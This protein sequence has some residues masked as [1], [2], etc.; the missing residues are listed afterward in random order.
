MNITRGTVDKI[1]IKR[2]DTGDW[3]WM[4]HFLTNAFLVAVLHNAIKF[5]TCNSVSRDENQAPTP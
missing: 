4:S 5:L 1:G 3:L 2:V